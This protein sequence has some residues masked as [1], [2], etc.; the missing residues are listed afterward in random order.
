MTRGVSP[1]ART[2]Y[3]RPGE[4][5]I[6]ATTQPL[7]GGALAKGLG[8]FLTGLALRLDHGATEATVLVDEQAAGMLG[9]PASLP[10]SGNKRQSLPALADMNG[11]KAGT[12]MPWTTYYR[13]GYPSLYVG[14]MPWLDTLPD[15]R[16]P[17]RSGDPAETAL[18]CYRW[19][20]VTGSA[21]R[22]TPGVTGTGMLRTLAAAQ[23]SEPT[24]QPGRQ[25]A[26]EDAY[27]CELD[28]TPGQWRA[29]A[30]GPHSGLEDGWDARLQYLAA[31]V[32]AE[33]PLRTLTR[34][35][36]RAAFDPKLGG[37]WRVRLS[38]WNHPGLPDP[39]GYDRG[40]HAGE[41]REGLVWRSTPTL[42][43]L[44]QLTTEG[45]YG[46]FEV[47]QA[48]VSETGRVTREWGGVLRDAH[49]LWDLAL[50]N[51]ER[52]A[53]GNAEEFRALKAAVKAC[54]RETIGLF[55]RAGG[56][57]D[58][59]EWQDTIVAQA[60]TNL[61]RKLWAAGKATGRWPAEVDRDTAWY[62]VPEDGTPGEP[63]EGLALGAGLGKFRHYGTRKAES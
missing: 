11:W 1:L 41:A 53:G 59:Q 31:A 52:G 25:Q 22:G 14:V 21:Y 55:G 49:A 23:R 2:F 20:A 9:L 35:K 42:A 47:D 57:I 7:P 27:R 13:E 17:L 58:R 19:H 44:D 40:F 32:V 37:Y 48:Y 60:R 8:P 38:T 43:L 33:L 54:Y 30:S 46:G 62:A 39:A 6:N 18:R 45:V 10:P 36:R 15:D 26:L 56:R 12:V 16:W 61:W 29:D 50:F 4:L 63:I 24:W 28:Y 3:V 5:M 34:P 51:A